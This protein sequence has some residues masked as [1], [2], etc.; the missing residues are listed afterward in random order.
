MSEVHPSLLRPLDPGEAFFTVIDTAFCMNFVV[1][2]ERDAALDRPALQCA[3][4][5]VQARHALL[6]T[7]LVW[8]AEAG[9][10]F[11]AAKDQPV[12]VRAPACDGATW[13][14]A[15]EAEMQMRFAPG[16]GPLVRALALQ[17]PDANAAGATR[18]V[19]ALCFHHAVAD[20]RSGVAVLR[21]VL[22]AYVQALAAPSMCP[23]SPKGLL[24]TPAPL[25]ALMPPDYRWAEAPQ[26]VKPLRDTVL[27]DY[28]RCGALSPLPWFDRA[29]PGPQQPGVMRIGLDAA[30]TQA[31]HARCRAQGTTLHGALAAAQLLAQHRLQADPAA[32][33][34]YAFSSPVDLRDH[35][36]GAPGLSPT[37]LYVS[38]VAA[39]FSVSGDTDF[40]ALARAVRAQTLAQL[41]RGEAHVFF[42]LNGFLGQ[43]VRPEWAQ[44]FRDKLQVA[45]PHTMLSNVG[46]VPMADDPAVTAISF[47]LC[48]MPHQT[49]FAAA[50]SYAGQLRVN[51]VVDRSRVAPAHALALQRAMQS[52]LAQAAQG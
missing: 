25:H 17:W 15:V 21:E 44:A 49:A 20:G 32:A 6:Q 9:L 2:A 7:C 52:C 8:D 37:A 28:R 22:A 4:A 14:Q 35:V 5:Q 42:A 10:C 26:R 33:A 39:S 16:L 50:S 31:L 51:L 36:Q 34:V 1:L 19:L 47:A 3:L 24:S 40:W 41:A 48:P 30:Q 13:V 27:A 11:A 46:A 12:P 38:I 18:S 23:P 29:S 43:P 45:P